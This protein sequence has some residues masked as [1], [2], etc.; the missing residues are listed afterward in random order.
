LAYV[1]GVDLGGTKILTALADSEGRIIRKVRMATPVSGGVEA[2]VDCLVESVR[3]VAAGVSLAAVGVGTPGPVDHVTG[4][5]HQAPNLG[6]KG[7]PLGEMLAGRLLAPVF[8][9]NDANCAALGEYRQGAGRGVRHLVYVTVSTGVG[10]GL[11]LDGRIYHG[12]SG[13]A[14]EIGHMTLDPLGP[15]CSCGRRGCLEACAS[16]TA[17]AREAR[18]RGFLPAPATA[19]EVAEAAR[20]G[21]REATAVLRDAFV[22][23]GRG[24]AAVITLLNPR[25]VVV[26]GGVMAGAADFLPVA[27]EEAARCTYGPAWERVEVV[28]A[29]LGADSGVTGAAALA[30]RGSQGGRE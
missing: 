20:R 15:L 7:V 9:E 25:L 6:W 14:G 8:V 1:A 21:D 18:K 29:F 3:K 11:I 26:G 24:L 23:L 16:G 27:R 4:L 30:V 17:I 22:Y 28:P 5:V 19:K 10:G 2:V 13:G 12:E